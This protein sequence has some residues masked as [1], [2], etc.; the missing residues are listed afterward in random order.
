MLELPLFTC[1][2]NSGVVVLTPTLPEFVLL[3]FWLASG[4]VHWAFTPAGCNRNK[5]TNNALQASMVSK[6]R[7]LWLLIVIIIS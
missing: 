2:G 4:V 3:M 5:V 6:P 7:N 1:R